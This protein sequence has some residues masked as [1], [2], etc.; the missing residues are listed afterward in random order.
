MITPKMVNLQILGY[1]KL[2][3]VGQR[4]VVDCFVKE[5]HLEMFKLLIHS[6][7]FTGQRNNVYQFASFIYDVDED[8]WIKERFYVSNTL[9]EAA[10]VLFMEKK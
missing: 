3:I 2:R 10:K 1:K 6:S 5:Q 7:S 4:K 9:T 8:K